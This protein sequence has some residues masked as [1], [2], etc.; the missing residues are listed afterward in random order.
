MAKKPQGHTRR[1]SEHAEES[2][3]KRSDIPGREHMQRPQHIK[4]QEVR[5]PGSQGRHTGRSMGEG[6]LGR[7][8]L[9]GRAN[10][11]RVSYGV[12]ITVE[13]DA[14]YRKSLREVCGR[15]A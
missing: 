5:G 8:K 13:T 3:G 14:V 10:R 4:F 15:Q 9:Q 7:Q 12:E 2:A 1:H 11:A 6:V